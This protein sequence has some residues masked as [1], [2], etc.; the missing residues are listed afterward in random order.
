[1]KMIPGVGLMSASSLHSELSD[2]VAPERLR[3]LCWPM[4][5][6]GFWEDSL[7]SF[8]SIAL[9]FFRSRIISVLRTYLMRIRFNEYHC[10]FFW[11]CFPIIEEGWSQFIIGFL[12]RVL[13]LQ[14]PTFT[15]IGQSTIPNFIYNF[16]VK[17]SVDAL[18]YFWT[19]SISFHNIFN[20]IF[21]FTFVCIYQP[22]TLIFNPSQTS[23]W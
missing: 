19:K 11:K 3:S 8:L 1:M 15:V 5:S 16:K 12:R 4:F 10:N 14:L 2:L 7:Q 21:L 20:I 17:I 23:G 18:K 6:I 22:R 13:H 9:V